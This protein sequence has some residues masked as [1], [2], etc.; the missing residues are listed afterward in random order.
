MIYTADETGGMERRIALVAVVLVLVLGS[1]VGGG[2]ALAQDD[3]GT[4]DDEAAGTHAAGAVGIEAATVAGAVEHA[5]FERDL[6]VTS[7]D[8]ARAET[9]AAYLNRSRNRLDTLEA[10]ER[11]L[12]EARENG[13]MNAGE[14]D[15]RA[16]RLGARAGGVA[17][18]SAAMAA[19]AADLPADLQR[20]YDVEPADIRD[21]ESRAETFAERTRSDAIRA[22]TAVFGDI[23]GMV[24]AYNANVGGDAGFL[25]DRLRDER[26]NL[27]VESPDGSVVVVSFRIDADGR[28]AEVRAGPRGDA[29]LRA[30]TDRAT[31][32][33]IADSGDPPATF[34]TA[35]RDD[36][37][38]V[39]GVGLIDRI[40]W[41]L[42]DLATA[43]Q[44]S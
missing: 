13:S 20:A 15:A 35:V 36:E 12:E 30:E 1:V 23:A 31:V 17:A 34:R 3:G 32:R 2:V 29:T 27:H 38:H 18:L 22:D 26:V 33:R 39:E 25:D 28:F 6:E 21:L 43:V 4:S 9:I 14:Y 24:D 40:I 8:E 41:R 19:A 16:A 7:T 5:R 44:S 37:I 11:E 42:V 10:R